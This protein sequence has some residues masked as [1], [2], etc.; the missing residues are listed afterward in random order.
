MRN[1]DMKCCNI[2]SMKRKSCPSKFPCN[3]YFTRIRLLQNAM[4][5]LNRLPSAVCQNGLNGRE[6]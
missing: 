5:D 3:V 1:E 2:I 4:E 6:A